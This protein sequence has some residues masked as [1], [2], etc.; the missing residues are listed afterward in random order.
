MVVGWDR[1]GP[2]RVM[3]TEWFWLGI[4]CKAGVATHVAVLQFAC[5]ATVLVK[6]RLHWGQQIVIG[7]GCA[8]C[9]KV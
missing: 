3:M 6:S 5:A 8:L 4:G 9:P 2:M 1:L 7:L